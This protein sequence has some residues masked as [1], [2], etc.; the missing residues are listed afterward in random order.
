MRLATLA[1][2]GLSALLLGC[3]TVDWENQTVSANLPFPENVSVT[4]P[5]V[6]DIPGLLGGNGTAS[7]TAEA[8]AAVP[9]KVKACVF[10]LHD[11][12]ADGIFSGSVQFGEKTVALDPVWLTNNA[13]PEDLAGCAVIML[14]DGGPASEG[15]YLDY[16]PRV[17][18]KQQVS[19]GSGLIVSREAGTL[20]HDDNAVRGWEY[21]LAGV[22][23]V[24]IPESPANLTVNAT[25][26]HAADDPAIGGISEFNVTDANITDVNLGSGKTIAL[27]RLGQYQSSVSYPAVVRG[28]AGRGLVYYV[29]FAPEA[30]PDVYKALAR[31]LATDYLGKTFE[32]G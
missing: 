20:V 16:V 9:D 21:V 32:V 24:S 22:V 3:I 25:F 4:V 27:F 18:V 30:A 31:F 26:V 6:S 17:A 23:P 15:R 2:L 1:F 13:K 7:P 14:N 5:P 10:G 11:A 19:S 28:G 12:V 8:S 29:S